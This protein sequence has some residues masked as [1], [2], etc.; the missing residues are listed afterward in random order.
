MTKDKDKKDQPAV[1]E[2]GKP[3]T[4]ALEEAIKDDPNDER[5]ERLKLAI[6]NH[7]LNARQTVK[8]RRAPK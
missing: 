4:D 7:A 1:S 2:S 6:K 5:I 8:A 3:F